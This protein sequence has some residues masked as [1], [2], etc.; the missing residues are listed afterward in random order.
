MIK[1]EELYYDSRDGINKI[2]AIRWIPE[3]EPKAVLQI[4]H[5]MSEYVD[6]Y[7]DFAERMAQKG[8]VVVG[9]DH[10]GHGRSVPEGGIY[11]YFCENDPATVVVRDVHRLKKLTQQEYPGL[12]Y[13]ILGH[14]MGSFIARNYLCKYGT[15]IDGAI[16]MSTGMQKKALVSSARKMV[17]IQKMIHGSK[18]VS[19]VL[20]KA[21]FGQYNKRLENPKTESD[22]LSKDE[23]KVE[24]YI[25]DSMCG[26]TFTVN[27]FQTL[28]ELIWRLYKQENLNSMPQELPVMFVAGAED[29]VGDYFEG[30]E[31]A[32][33][34]FKETG[35][36]DITVKKYEKARHELLNE[37]E[38]E[39]VADDIYNWISEKL[40]VLEAT[41]E[42]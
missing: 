25:R 22:W 27:G 37:T 18:Y 40:A 19:T 31:R 20:D 8:F 21:V 38:W 24:A 1:K 3:S 33:E 34:S 4:V 41:D 23:K 32:V 15:G 35:M 10:L 14:S 16:I 42:E 7:H 28:F 29:P 13:F 11:G 5:G 39:Q 6:R 36:Q 17:A 12:P 9:N 26:F 30:V 2:H